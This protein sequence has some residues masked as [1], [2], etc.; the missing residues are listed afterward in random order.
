[1][2]AKIKDCRFMKP[3]TAGFK[4]NGKLYRCLKSAVA[5]GMMYIQGV[6]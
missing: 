4:V 2:F 3:N 1:M 6:S 5:N